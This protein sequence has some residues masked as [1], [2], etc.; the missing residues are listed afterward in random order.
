[1]WI[2]FTRCRFLVA[3]CPFLVARCRF[4]VA[5]C[6]FFIAQCPFLVAQS[7][8]FVTQCRFFFAQCPFLATQC[9]FFVAQCPLLATQCQ[10][11]EMKGWVTLCICNFNCFIIQLLLTLSKLWR[12]LE[13]AGING[14][15]DTLAPTGEVHYTLYMRFQLFH[16]AAKGAETMKVRNAR[17]YRGC[18]INTNN[19][20]IKHLVY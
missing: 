12:R 10:L 9:R 18:I 1:M 14:T 2:L 11:I 5:Q 15:S 17:A 3:Q 13:A 4:F 7:R 19:W 20:E 8:F 16:G 6:L